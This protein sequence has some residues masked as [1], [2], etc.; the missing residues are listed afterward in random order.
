MPRTPRTTN[1]KQVTGNKFKNCQLF[2]GGF[3]LIEIV[4]SLF[5]ILG[6]VSILLTASG[7]LI[8]SR[9]SGLQST[10][11][12][13]ASRQIESLRNTSFASLPASGNFDDADL[14]KLPQGAATRTITDYQNNSKIKLVN[15]RVNWTES[16]VAKQLITE[17]LISENGL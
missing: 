15:I 17:T 6:L 1:S 8:H 12:K 4:L 10:A 16:E 3:S 13:I 7:T 2:K 11:A 5:L 14:A 9:N